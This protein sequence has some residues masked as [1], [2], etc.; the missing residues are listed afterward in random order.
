MDESRTDAR[1]LRQQ[2]ER[3]RRVEAAWQHIQAAADLL[4]RRERG[5]EEP[6]LEVAR[7]LVERLCGALVGETED[8]GWKPRAYLDA[9]D[10][11]RAREG[12]DPGAGARELAAKLLRLLGETL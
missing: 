12:L 9:G 5:E 7:D 11:R 6:E 1:L 2:A 8:E 3:L 10:V 4:A